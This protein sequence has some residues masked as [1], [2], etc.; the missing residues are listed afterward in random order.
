MI[1]KSDEVEVYKGPDEKTHENVKK[2]ERFDIMSSIGQ[3]VLKTYGE[4]VAT[5]LKVF[6][7]DKLAEEWG[8]IPLA[9]CFL[10]FVILLMCFASLGTETML[11]MPQVIII[12][13]CIM[14]FSS[15]SASSAYPNHLYI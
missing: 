3:G 4:G 10:I 6:L 1:L 7:P 5:S 9:C 13:L 15:S 2:I 12:V 8:V 14:C 11:M